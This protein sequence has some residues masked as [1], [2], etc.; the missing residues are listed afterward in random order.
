MVTP[1]EM[2]VG[3]WNTEWAPASGIRATMVRE[4]LA[5]ATAD[6]LVVTEGRRDLL[7]GGGHVA[8]GG[9][10]WGYGQQRDRR[11]V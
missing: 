10:D 3:T 11:K 8:D 7:P 1:D 9:D 2:T 4:R 5:A 6:V